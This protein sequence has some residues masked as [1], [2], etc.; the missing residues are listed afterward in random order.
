MTPL[1]RA[2]LAELDDQALSELARR[3]QPYMAAPAAL[4]DDGWLDTRDAAAYAGCTVDSLHKAA[5]AGEVE[6]EQRVERGK[7][8]FQKSKLDAWR[9]GE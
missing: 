1:A 5:A 3:L 6:F 4:I 9:R 2:L 8:F 7:M